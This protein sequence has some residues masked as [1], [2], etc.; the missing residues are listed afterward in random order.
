MDQ[1]NGLSVKT[2]GKHKVE[3]FMG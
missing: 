2:D 3:M 1:E